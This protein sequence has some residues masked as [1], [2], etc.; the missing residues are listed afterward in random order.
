MLLSWNYPEPLT[1]IAD[2]LTLRFE[3]AINNNKILFF[4]RNINYIAS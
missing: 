4:Y 1:I 3:Y 2:A